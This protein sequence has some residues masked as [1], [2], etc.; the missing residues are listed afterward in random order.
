MRSRASP[1][2]S[3]SSRSG[4]PPFDWSAS[5]LYIPGVGRRVFSLFFW[6]F[7]VVSSILLFPIAARH[8]GA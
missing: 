6:A 3:S 5:L 2:P 4:R 1:T 7:L 8:L